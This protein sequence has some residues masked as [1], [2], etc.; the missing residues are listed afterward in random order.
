[1]N[2]LITRALCEQALRRIARGDMDGLETI[3]DKLGRLRTVNG[4]QSIEGAYEDIL[5]AI[6]AK[7]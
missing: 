3:Y 2:D 4:S 1:M 6:G 7:V 5:K